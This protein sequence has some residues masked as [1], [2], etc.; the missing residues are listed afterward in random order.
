MNNA[1]ELE[2]IK[3]KTVLVVDDEEAIRSIITAYLSDLEL[4][5]ISVDSIE[6]ARGCLNSFSIDLI[7][8]DVALPGN[9]TGIDFLA[10]CRNEHIHSPFI[11]VSGFVTPEDVRFALS[12]GVQHVIHKPFRKEQLINAI[13]SSFAVSDSYG[14]LVDS[15]IKEIELNQQL[16]MS[17]IDGFAA[18]IG[19]RDGYTFE[20]SEQVADLAVL[21]SRKIGL[22]EKNIQTARIAGKLHDIGKIGVPENIL[23]KKELLTG[24]EYDI[25]KS[26]P[27]KA[28]QILAPLPALAAVVDGAKH[29]HER[30][31]GTG[32][33]DGLKGEEIPL[34]GRIL[35]ICDA[36]SAMTTDRPYR[37]A[38]L[39]EE[40]RKELRLNSSTQ[41]DPVLVEA[42]L[43][44]PEVA[45]AGN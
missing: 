22:D 5:V 23:L 45:E 3:G 37:A 40:A 15:Y 33:P 28:A 26:H 9:E 31:D 13:L 18:A 12:K 7:I 38:F 36:F 34:L 14:N 41:F 24:T 11:L 30:F 20:H 8:S 17:A 21:L 16:F 29:H 10:W 32:Y 2:K 39:A 25:M 44:L 19:A 42:F 6:K 27:L 1:V 43:T 4:V 35:A